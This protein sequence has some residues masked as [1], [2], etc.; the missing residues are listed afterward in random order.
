MTKEQAF[1]R[2]RA[3][4]SQKMY[5]DCIRLCTKLINNGDDLSYGLRGDSYYEINMYS[6]SISDI[7]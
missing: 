4:F 5:E 7:I 1:S 3:Y 2:A 6:E